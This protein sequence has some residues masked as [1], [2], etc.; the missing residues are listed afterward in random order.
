MEYVPLGNT[1]RTYTPLVVQVIIRNLKT[2][3]QVCD[4]P[5][6]WSLPFS[7]LNHLIPPV[8]STSA[9][10]PAPLDHKIL[11]IEWSYPRAKFESELV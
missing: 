9:A 11:C 2:D 8:S 6:V 5:T 10:I 3:S 4:V 1:N 7:R